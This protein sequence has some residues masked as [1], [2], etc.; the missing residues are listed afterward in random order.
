MVQLD[1]NNMPYELLAIPLV[2]SGYQVLPP[3]INPVEAAG[4]WQIIPQTPQKYDLVINGRRDDRMDTERSTQGA[5]AYL[6]KLH[7]Q[8][9]NWG[10]A[11]SS[12]EI[13]EKNVA[14]L[15]QQTGS[16]NVWT[17]ARSPQAPKDLG[18]FLA[19]FDASLIIMKNPEILK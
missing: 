18:Q 16:K 6:T 5:L 12:Y 7:T 15:I 17:L 13:G 1:K 11:V 3:N 8:F 10:L 2:E 19:T 14:N 9:N 4:I